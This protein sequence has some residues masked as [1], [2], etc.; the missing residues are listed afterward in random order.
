MF[1]FICR[2]RKIQRLRR[3]DDNN[4]GNINGYINY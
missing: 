4:N 2:S 1:C 3:N